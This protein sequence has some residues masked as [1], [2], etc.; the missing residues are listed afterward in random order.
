MTKHHEP[1]EVIDRRTQTIQAD[2]QALTGTEPVP[3]PEPE[4]GIGEL[5]RVYDDPKPIF[6]RVLIMRNASATV[7]RGTKFIIPETAQKS[8]NRGVVV[9]TADFYI[10]EGKAF[11]VKDI[12][13]PGDLVTFSGFNTEDIDVDGETFTLCSVF[14]LKLIEKCHFALGVSSAVGA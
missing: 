5:D 9:A 12:V 11:P 2:A 10:V 7:W 6:D 3:S 14:D 4:R 1:M 13:E 8:A